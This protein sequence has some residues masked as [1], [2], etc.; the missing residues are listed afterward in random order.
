LKILIVRFS[1]IG[2]IVLTSPIPRIAKKQL[3]AEVHFITKSQFVNLINNNPN[4][5]KVYS[6]EKNIDEVIPQLK[7]EKYDYIIDLHNSLRSKILKFK[8]GIKSLKVNKKNFD[9]WM[10][11][12]LKSKKQITHIVERYIQTLHSLGAKNDN[13]GLDFYYKTDNN[14]FKKFNIV[15]PYICISLGAKHFTKKIPV[16]ILIDILNKTNTNI[17][18]IGGNDVSNEATKIENKL[19]KKITNLVGKISIDQSAQ[20]I[21]NS[22]AVLTSDTGMMHI[23]ASLKKETIVLWGNTVPEFGMSPYYGE[24]N[25]KTKNFEVTNLSCRPCSK[26]GFKKCPKGHFNCMNKQNTEQIAMTLNS[27][28]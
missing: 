9:K 14:L 5:D 6:F 7:E 16:N 20:I 25:I 27:I 24:Y 18:L 11:V 12:N 19:N 2:D 1:S 4:I 3:K 8:L 17:V 26:I 21:D 22:K 13:K 15:E 28:L 23:A 10:M